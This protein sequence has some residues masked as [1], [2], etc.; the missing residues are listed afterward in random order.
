[1]QLSHNAPLIEILLAQA[2]NATDKDKVA[3][4]AVTL[5]RNAIAREP[6]APDAYTQLAM[7]YGRKGDLANADLASAQAAFA[8]GD[9]MTA[10]Q[11]AARAKTPFPGRLAGLGA[12]RR[13]HQSQADRQSPTD[14]Q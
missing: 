7:A 10:R 4:E 8:R 5:L 9:I 11:L 3:D 13:H 2:L 12:R 14:R 1:M 6:D